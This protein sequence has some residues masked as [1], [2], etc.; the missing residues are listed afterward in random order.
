MARKRTR[1]KRT[2]RNAPCPCGSGKK[3][4]HCCEKPVPQIQKNFIDA[5][6]E[7]PK[8]NITYLFDTCVWSEIAKDENT[9]QSF[10]SF[11]DSNNL[12]AG[13]TVFSLFELSRATHLIQRLDDLFLSGHYHIWIPLLYDQV[14]DLEIESYPNPPTMRW[15]PMS[16]IA[17]DDQP[18]V[19]SKFTNDSRFI[20]KRDEFLQFGYDE[21]ISLEKFKENYPP[22]KDENYTP[23]QARDFCWC[24]AVD[25]LGRHFREFLQQ[26]KDDASAFD[27]S[28]IPSIQMRSLLL[29]YKYYIYGQSPKESDFPD[30]AITSYVPYSNVFVTERNVL[31]AMK[32]IERDGMLPS[33]TSFL[34]VNEFIEGVLS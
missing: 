33:A 4:K 25:F 9:A 23:D 24:N 14:S 18:E 13:I 3:Y 6:I 26:F 31:N 5:F 34:H 19:M 20:H 7:L 10:L 29:F 8:A 30:F 16:L 21:F 17:D 27:S 2:K 15:M 11:F 28:K 12:L 32:H 22:G 1:V